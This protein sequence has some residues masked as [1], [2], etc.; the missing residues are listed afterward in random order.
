M[1]EPINE[2][3]IIDVL[4]LNCKNKGERDEYTPL[5]FGH[6]FEYFDID[7]RKVSEPIYSNF[8]EACEVI[9]KEI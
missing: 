9:D 1:R 4:G 2:I 5:Y 3:Q 6:N 8:T 7:N